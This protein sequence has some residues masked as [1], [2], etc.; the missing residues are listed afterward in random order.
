MDSSETNSTKGSD[1]YLNA[2]PSTLV[3]PVAF[4]M[5]LKWYCEHPQKA[6]R[7]CEH[8]GDA[9][10][11]LLGVPGAA[12]RYT[13]PHTPVHLKS[14]SREPHRALDSARMEFEE[15]YAGAVM[16]PLSRGRLRTFRRPSSCA[17][18]SGPPGPKSARHRTGRS[19]WTS[20]Q[21]P[22]EP[23]SVPCSQPFLAAPIC[24]P[25]AAKMEAPLPPCIS[26]RNPA[27]GFTSSQ[28]RVKKPA[29]YTGLGLA[30]QEKNISPGH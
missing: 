1:R 22:G 3:L 5:H 4:G 16:L 30:R 25:R 14:N 12:R 13:N 2:F 19:Q 26:I 21:H 6:V 23:P 29:Q 9:D 10:E 7:F 27:K 8:N 20:A 28:W 24:C 17:G 15:N 11:I 18:G